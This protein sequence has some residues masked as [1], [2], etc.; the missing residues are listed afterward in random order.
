MSQ[1]MPTF[2]KDYE[3]VEGVTVIAGDDR[4]VITMSTPDF[5]FPGVLF[6]VKDGKLQLDHEFNNKV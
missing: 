6:I 2:I 5:E 3:D 4:I 1:P